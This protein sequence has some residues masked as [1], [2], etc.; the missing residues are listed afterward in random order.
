MKS[1]KLLK[2]VLFSLLQR[3]LQ[4]ELKIMPFNF[5]LC[6]YQYL[7]NLA[8]EFQYLTNL[9]LKNDFKTGLPKATQ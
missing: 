5:K 4:C 3:G 9:W 1:L 2:F 7:V 6:E 8:Q